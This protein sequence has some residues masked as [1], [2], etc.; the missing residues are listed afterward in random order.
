MTNLQDYTIMT[1]ALMPLAFLLAIWSI[2]Y[3]LKKLM[4][5]GGWIL[6]TIGVFIMGRDI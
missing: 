5:V 4:L 1:V 6:G 3:M 2:E